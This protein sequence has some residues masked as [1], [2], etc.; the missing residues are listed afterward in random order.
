LHMFGWILLIV[1]LILDFSFLY[2]SFQAAPYVPMRSNDLAKALEF[3]QIKPRDKFFDL[4]AGDGRI[5]AAAEKSG[6][7]AIGYEISLMPFLVAKL[8][9]VFSRAKFE[10]LFKDFWQVDLR[11]ADV[12]FAFLMP[13]VMPRLKE[14]LEKELRSGARVISYA[15]LVPDWTPTAVHDIGGYR[16]LFLYIK[17]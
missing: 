16:K 6:A 15:W 8:R 4:G 13:R 17:K 11:D 9:K 1:I 2:A 14:K 12:V 3:M 5:L 7:R 10:I